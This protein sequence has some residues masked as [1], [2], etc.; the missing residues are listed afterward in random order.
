MSTKTTN[1]LVMDFELYT[2]L[3]AEL[4]TRGLGCRESGAF[5][6]ARGTSNDSSDMPVRI[7]GVAYYDDLDPHSLNGAV[8]FSAVGYSALS[9]HCRQEDQRVVA[10]IHTHPGRHVRQSHTDRTN[11]MVAVPGHVAL[12]APNYAQG[13]ICPES[14]GVHILE[15]GGQWQS[16]FEHDVS[17]LLAVEGPASKIRRI[18]DAIL[19]F[20]RR[21]PR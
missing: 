1:Q 7:V 18:R 8:S 5:L 2:D 17:T 10:D 13:V 20:F 4:A 15:S 9:A 16:L 19:H 6:L 11:P 21:T 3:M 14:I 12:I